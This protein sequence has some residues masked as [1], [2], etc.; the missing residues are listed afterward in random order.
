MKS[1]LSILLITILFISTTGCNHKPTVPQTNEN[2]SESITPHPKTNTEDNNKEDS[3]NK[4]NNQ[5]KKIDESLVLNQNPEFKPSFGST[6]YLYSFPKY[7][8]AAYEFAI[9]RK[10]DR[11]NNLP[12]TKIA[13]YIVSQYRGK[14]KPLIWIEKCQ[15]LKVKY[16][17]FDEERL[18]TTCTTGFILI[19]NHEIQKVFGYK[20]GILYRADT[21]KDPDDYE[22]EIA[23]K[24]PEEEESNLPIATPT[25]YV[26]YTLFLPPNHLEIDGLPVLQAV[27]E[28]YES[29]ILPSTPPSQL[30]R[31]YILLDGL[32]KFNKKEAY[33]FT[34]GT[35]YGLKELH[36]FFRMGVT[37]DHT[38]YT[39]VIEPVDTHKTV[40]TNL[41]PPVPT[42]YGQGYGTPFSYVRKYY[43]N[44]NYSL[45][46]PAPRYKLSQPL[47]PEVAAFGIVKLFDSTLLNNTTLFEPQTLQKLK[48]SP[49]HQVTIYKDFILTTPNRLRIEWIGVDRIHDEEVL[50]FNVNS[51][52]VAVSQSGKLYTYIAKPVT[53]G[54]LTTNSNLPQ[55]EK[56][57]N[58]LCFDHRS[59]RTGPMMKD[60]IGYVSKRM[61]KDKTVQ[62][63]PYL[64]PESSEPY[65]D[66]LIDEYKGESNA[67][68]W[69]IN[70]Y[71]NGNIDGKKTYEFEAGQEI[72]LG[73]YLLRFKAA[74]SENGNI[75]IY[76]NDTPK[77]VRQ[78]TFD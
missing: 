5:N 26:H 38:Y 29:A 15:L 24:I 1:S 28:L 78:I 17:L 12:I 76:E 60:I 48:V 55:L 27:N 10:F 21:T 39:Y 34:I 67:M 51:R 32:T 4:E 16:K 68:P 41:A 37:S 20:E 22:P 69:R 3:Q 19:V 77:F 9:E 75:Y 47:T 36:Q 13:N 73:D 7:D 58:H 71:A 54:K 6:S 11:W 53:G 25:E 44:G 56:D 14:E 57:Y 63:L 2:E 62:S 31:F 70:L 66:A 18:D 40:P 46:L 49:T 30:D 8:I 42:G 33:E 23:A 43:Q 61:K 65:I 35:G 52:I 59:Q 45:E 50:I 74:I 64:S 72:C